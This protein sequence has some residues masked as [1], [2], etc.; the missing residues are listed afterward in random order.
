MYMGKDKI[1]AFLSHVLL[2]KMFVPEYINS[3]GCQ[4]WYISTLFQFY[5]FFIPLAKVKAKMKNMPFFCLA[6]TISVAWWIFIYWMDL[7]SNRCWSSFFLQ[8]IWE[9]VFGMCVAEI[10]IKGKTIKINNKYLVIGALLG[11]TLTV[12]LVKAGD[13]FKAFNDIPSFVGFISAVLL[14]Y[15]IGKKYIKNI[16]D[17]ISKYSYEW[18]LTHILVFSILDCIL[19]IRHA[20]VLV[21]CVVLLTVSFV[22]SV[23]YKIMLNN[24]LNLN[25][26]KSRWRVWIEKK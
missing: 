19:P 25:G 12:V 14:V 4:F 22:V 24:C 6:F 15:S 1:L 20:P 23:I 16:I 18:Y 3:F 13:A 2:F 17:I 9:F 5:L 26:S 10:L 7:S 8:Y 21:K 11:G